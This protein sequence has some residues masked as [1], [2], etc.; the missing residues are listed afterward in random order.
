ML[1]QS[2]FVG[3]RRVLLSHPNFVHSVKGIEGRIVGGH[4]EVESGQ[5]ICRYTNVVLFDEF[6]IILWSW[7]C[8]LSTRSGLFRVPKPWLLLLSSRSRTILTLHK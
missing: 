8:F 2:A 7:L 6:Q 3:R 5:L 1:C 4:T